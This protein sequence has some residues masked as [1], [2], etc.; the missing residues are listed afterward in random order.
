MRR[1]TQV[2]YSPVAANYRPLTWED[3]VSEGD[4]NRSPIFSARPRNRGW[5]S[6]WWICAGL[7]V[8]VAGDL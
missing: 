8:G 1:A 5:V 4:L 3:S 2:P 7:F 6:G